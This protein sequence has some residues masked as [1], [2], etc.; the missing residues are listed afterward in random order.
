MKKLTEFHLHPIE[1]LAIN[2]WNQEWSAEGSAGIQTCIPA[3]LGL[4]SS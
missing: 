1:Q 3:S 4:T 2:V